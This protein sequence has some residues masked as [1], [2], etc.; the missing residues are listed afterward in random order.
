MRNFEVYLKN[1][2]YPAQEWFKT[3]GVNW[4]KKH[5]P[6]HDWILTNY[7]QINLGIYKVTLNDVIVYVGQAVKVSNRLV[8][9]AWHLAKEPE[10]FYGVLQSEL[11]KNVVQ[12]N[13]ECIE[14]KIQYNIT[15]EQKEAHYIQELAP[16]LQIEKG[17]SV[18]L[19]KKI[20][21]DLCIYPK[22]KR[23][24]ITQEKLNLN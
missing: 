10:R 24:G 12:I 1:E 9:H 3:E 21:Y 18:I 5:I 17:K 19:N 4:I 6:N 13:M 16:Y 2:Y 23:R 7:N 8:V 15:R 20:K 14:S 22:G 11:E